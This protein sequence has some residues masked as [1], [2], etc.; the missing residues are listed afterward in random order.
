MRASKF[1]IIMAAAFQIVSFQNCDGSFAVLPATEEGASITDEADGVL[2]ADQGDMYFFGFAKAAIDDPT[3]QQQRAVDANNRVSGAIALWDRFKL[4]VLSEVVS[5][6]PA[7]LIVDKNVVTARLNAYA[8]SLKPSDTLVIY[9]HSHGLD[10]R[11]APDGSTREGGLLVGVEQGIGKMT[12][13]EYAEHLLSLPAKNVIVFTM[14]CFS[15]N[16]VEILNTPALKARWENRRKE[17]RSFVVITAQNSDLLSGPANINGTMIN[18]L[19]Y[20]IE[21]AFAGRA[22]GHRDEFIQGTLD[23]RLTLGELVYYTL[24]TSRTAGVG[25][26]NDSQMIGSFDPALVL[27]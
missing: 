22:D 23:G 5:N 14:A 11:L 15:G 6:T 24:H 12:W 21:Q 27:Q 7:Q 13:S 16:L 18:A 26:T 9:S 20:A 17:G 2:E 3:V 4:D 1:L 8:G 19:P 25:N 10:N